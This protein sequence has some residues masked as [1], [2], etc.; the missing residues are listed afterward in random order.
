VKV[1]VENN[2]AL[3]KLCAGFV[4]ASGR[5]ESKGVHVLSEQEVCD[6]LEFVVENTYIKN[7][8]TLLR[9]A[10]GM[11]QGTNCAP[12]LANLYL[13]AYEFQFMDKL[14]LSDLTAARTF[15]FSFRFIDDLM[16]TLAHDLTNRLYISDTHIGLY[17]KHILRLDET[18]VSQRGDVGDVVNYLGM[19]IENVKH[20]FEVSVFDK[21]KEFGFPVVMYPHLFSNIPHSQAF[22]VF[23]GQVARF[24]R[25]CSTIW[26]H[27]ST[28]HTSSFQ[29]TTHPKFFPVC[30]HPSSTHAKTS[31]A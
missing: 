30:F 9:Q 31:T 26:P 29:R 12:F 4:S 8:T 7:G 3:N 19:R 23:I 28:L 14:A 25:I 6:L 2:F 11:P 20:K 15:K 27:A 17:P 16:F 21:R 5:Q 22:G 1:C 13:Y 10:I 24:H 18:T